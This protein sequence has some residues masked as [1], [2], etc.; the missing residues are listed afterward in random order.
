MHVSC[1]DSILQNVLNERLSADDLHNNGTTTYV[2]MRQP[3]LMLTSLQH[4][5]FGRTSTG[6]QTEVQRPPH[7]LWSGG[8]AP[9]NVG[10]TNI[11]HQIG[12]GTL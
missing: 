10:G 1:A 5:V 7:I 11:L 4:A 9:Q 3:R 8:T 12:C 6:L 2:L